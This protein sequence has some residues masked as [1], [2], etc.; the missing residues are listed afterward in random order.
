MGSRIH[1][2]ISHRPLQTANAMSLQYLPEMV[3]RALVGPLTL[4][5][6]RSSHT[7]VDR[8]EGCSRRWLWLAVHQLTRMTCP[9]APES[10]RRNGN[11]VVELK[12]SQS[13]LLLPTSNKGW[14][15]VMFWPL[16][17]VCLWTITS[18]GSLTGDT[19]LNQP[20]PEQ[21][22]RPIFWKVRVAHLLLTGNDTVPLQCGM[23]EVFALLSAIYLSLLSL[24]LLLLLMTM[25]MIVIVMHCDI[26]IRMT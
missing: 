10:T 14:P 22:V 2:G 1:A 17:F 23:A 25:F 13:T 12:H 15:G 20:L 21:L 6:G 16:L 24:S 26:C 9:M 11:P 8:W 19:Y 7:G 5:C 18:L 4:A 3:G